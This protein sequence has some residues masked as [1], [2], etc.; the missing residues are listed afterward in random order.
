MSGR[1]N[2]K[3]V[4]AALLNIVDAPSDDFDPPRDRFGDGPP[5][6]TMP[7]GCPV[8][9]V[10]TEDNVYYFLTALGELRGLTADKVANKHIVGMF[11]PESDFL[12]QHWPRKKLVARTD[13]DGNPVVDENGDEVMEMRITGWRPD[14]VSIQ[15]MDV[16]A[17]RGV[18][19]AREKVRGRGAW[20]GSDGGLILHTGNH[21]LIGG[22]WQKPGMYDGMVYPTAP[23]IP[24]PASGDDAHA[25]G[26]VL[27]P[28]LTGMLRA[29]GVAIAE[30][31]TPAQLLYQFLKT[32][33]WERPSVDPV[34]LLGWIAGAMMGGALD[35]RPL[36]WITGGAKTGKST[37]QKVI[38]LLFGGGI[39]QSSEA[40]EAGVRQVLGQQSLPVGLDETEATEDNRKLN[41][42]VKLARLAATSQG[43]ILR[44][45]QDHKGH[46]FR[47]T[48]CFLF[49]SILVPPMPPQDASRIAMLRLDALPAGSRKPQVDDRE[50]EAIGVWLRRRLADGWPRW[51]AVLE[52]FTDGLI[53]A[54][55]HDNRGADQFGT[56]LA[57]F[58]ILTDEGIPDIDLTAAWGDKLKVSELAETADQ[59]NEGDQCIR[60]LS[61]S[62]VQLPGHGA[63]KLVAE[64]VLQA[65]QPMP[66]PSDLA[67]Q[68]EV[69]DRRAQADRMLARIGL[70]VV[71]RDTPGQAECYLAVAVKFDSLGRQFE[72]TRWQSGVWAQAL[73]YIAGAKANQNTRI[74]GRQTKAVHVPIGAVVTRDEDE[75]E[76]VIDAAAD[77][78]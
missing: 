47:A 48:S 19:N 69:K 49:S 53:D 38:G 5:P 27:A 77:Q 36:A 66:P 68:G 12:F 43:N 58:Y 39:L 32:W 24:K 17:A 11:A 64:W 1:A 51:P 42:L 65:S 23:P 16:A 8:V 54:G 26:P 28:K 71:G 2:L 21:V 18:W 75:D 70:K 60:H 61:T 25:S 63:S 20:R 13:P 45:G 9:P 76:A 50:I 57:G 30:D 56:L 55:K 52:E 14:D 37:L 6:K 29:R 74:A 78:F 31:V 33:N 67:G 15:L 59:E 22:R 73:R 7:E 3:P 10:G 46:E 72:G 62:M 34:L 4:Q 40:S 44:G 35:Y 41:A